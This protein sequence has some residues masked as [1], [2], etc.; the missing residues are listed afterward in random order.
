MPALREDIAIAMVKLK[1]Y[2]SNRFPDLSILEAMFTDYQSISNYAM[3]YIALA[4]E[5]KLISGYPDET[6]RPQR[7]LTRAEA[8]AIIYKAYQYGN[9]NKVGIVS[10]IPSEQEQLSN[11]GIPV[12]QENQD[13]DKSS[14]IIYII[15]GNPQSQTPSV[16][17]SVYGN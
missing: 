7:P 6:I 9:D 3:N 17:D 13:S 4:V 12:L 5:N 15:P 14:E 10:E 16:T 2:N 8:A 1:G 11:V